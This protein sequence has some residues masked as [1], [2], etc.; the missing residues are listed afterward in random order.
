MPLPQ[1]PR[2]QESAANGNVDDASKECSQPP[3]KI[4]SP[5]PSL[6][7]YDK[8]KMTRRVTST[9]QKEKPVAEKP[10]KAAKLDHPNS[11]KAPKKAG[12]P[13]YKGCE[14]RCMSC[15]EM[16]G[17]VELIRKHVLKL[18]RVTHQC[19]KKACNL[20]NFYMTRM[21]R[22][23]CVICGANMLR[24]YWVIKMHVGKIH[25]MSMPEYA[26]GYVNKEEPEVESEEEEEL[27]A[28]RANIPGVQLYKCPYCQKAYEK[29]DSLGY[30]SRTM[31]KNKKALSTCRLCVRA[32]TDRATKLV[33]QK[34][35]EHLDKV[36]QDNLQTTM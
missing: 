15:G 29:P 13:F 8:V 20:C 12:K 7:M 24:D 32:F 16:R 22:Y 31:H 25:K 34:T 3:P 27:D 21:E 6:Y 35:K 36:E 11:T 19:D 2:E 23:D 1:A 4:C 5:T 17:S 30:H 14:Y 9:K 18:H 28:P 33:H 26:N 10:V